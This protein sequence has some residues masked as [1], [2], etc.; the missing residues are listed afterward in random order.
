LPRLVSFNSA[1]ATFSPHS[2]QKLA[3]TEILPP[4][5]VQNIFTF[6]PHSGQNFASSL[7]E[8]LQFLH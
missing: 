6:S 2:P 5:E 7:K 1:V 8:V 4:Q 3:L